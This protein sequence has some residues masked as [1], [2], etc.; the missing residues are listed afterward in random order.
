MV[1]KC[2]AVH[3]FRK[4]PVHAIVGGSVA[5]AACLLVGLHALDGWSDHPLQSDPHRT[6]SLMLEKEG[7]SYSQSYAPPGFASLLETKIP[8]VEHVTR[9]S[10]DRVRLDP[11][12]GGD[13][14]SGQA[15]RV[16]RAG[17]SF[18]DVFPG[19]P[20][21]YADRD[22]VLNAPGEAVLTDTAAKS[23][24][25]TQIPIGRVL[26]AEADSTSPIQ[27]VPSTMNNRTE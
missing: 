23:M 24:F 12:P 13:G 15:S 18:F 10:A 22:E 25:G 2:L 21:R 11:Q 20:V 7:P 5:V 3:T 8:G 26:R 14:V 17:S 9:T 16:L 4:R 19:F 1:R 6:L 27:C